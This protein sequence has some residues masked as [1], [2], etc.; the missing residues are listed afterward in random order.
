M[1][2]S[3]PHLQFAYN[4]GIAAG[5]VFRD[6]SARTEADKNSKAEDIFFYMDLFA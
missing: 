4:V 3:F 5:P 6:T 2:T 1:C